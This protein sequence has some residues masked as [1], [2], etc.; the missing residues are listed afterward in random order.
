MIQPTNT[1]RLV[2]RL[3][4]KPIDVAVREALIKHPNLEAAAVALGVSSDT[5]RRWRG[6][7]EAGQA[8]EG[9]AR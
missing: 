9:E 8:P 3:T 2:E 1:T 7:L 4:K 5:V 6:Q